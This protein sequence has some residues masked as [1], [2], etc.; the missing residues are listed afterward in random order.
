M[1]FGRKRKGSGTLKDNLAEWREIREGKRTTADPDEGQE[2][3]SQC[4]VVTAVYGTPLA[5]EVN[6]MRTFRDEF[7]LRYQSGRLFVST[8]YRVSPPAARFISSRRHLRSF[9]RTVLL[10]PVVSMVKMTRS[11]WSHQP[12]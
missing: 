8:Y 1:I 7:L 5:Q 6:T 10:A 3:D 4:F 12:G 9:L 11:R 2:K